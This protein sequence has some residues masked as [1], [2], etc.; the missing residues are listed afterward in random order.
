MKLYYCEVPNPRKPCAVAKH[1]D[2][3]LDYVRVDL[4]TREQQT[5]DYLAINPNGKVPALIDGDVSLFE[6]AAIMMY[7]AQ[8]AKSDIWPSAPLA[9]VDVVKWLVWDTAHF[10]R[11]ASTVYF[12][13]LI[14]KQFDLG[15]PDPA[16]VDEAVGFFRQFASVLNEH[17]VG[18]SYLVG[19]TLTIADFSVTTYL[20]VA[21][22]AE[23]SQLPIAEFGEIKRWHNALMD[24]PALNDP[25]PSA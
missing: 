4:Q 7:L 22:E 12:E 10:S 20:S 3:P 18:R 25:W 6:S 5:P 24:I 19:D 17:L 23:L 11:H 13:Y 15:K 2:V 9:Q 8:H 21:V 14:K 1:L 16:V